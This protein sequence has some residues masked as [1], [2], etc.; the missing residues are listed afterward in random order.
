VIVSTHLLAA[1]ELLDGATYYAEQASVRVAEKFIAEFERSISLL[2]LQPKLGA[3]WRGPFR[4]LPLR[5]FP[6]SIVY[7]LSGDVIRV[8]A[9][10]HQRRRPGYWQ[11]RV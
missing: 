4:R 7:V 9:L 1:D 2:R 11:S 5:R 10:A 3:V 8:V 6:H